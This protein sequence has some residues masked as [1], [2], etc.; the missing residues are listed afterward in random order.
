MSIIETIR[1]KEKVASLSFPTHT[2]LEAQSRSGS[3]AVSSSAITS[4]Q[5]ARL[6]PSMLMTEASNPAITVHTYF[7]TGRETVPR[8]ANS[9]TATSFTRAPSARLNA[10]SLNEEIP[11]GTSVEPSVERIT[12]IPPEAPPPSAISLL[13]DEKSN[14]SPAVNNVIK[15][16]MVH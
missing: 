15:F 8:S 2:S 3:E 12:F 4:R 5:S 13:H 9:S 11:S 6:S 1:P 7:P 16:F 14:S 10:S